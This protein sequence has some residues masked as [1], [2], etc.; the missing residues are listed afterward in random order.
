MQ[1]EPEPTGIPIVLNGF[2]DVPIL[3][4]N[5]F[6]IQYET[7][8][9]ILTAGQLTPPV[10]L[11]TEE[12]QREQ[13]KRI[14]HVSVKVVARISMNRTRLEQLNNLLTDHLRRF[15]PPPEGSP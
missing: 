5:N 15:S 2:E 4:A 14:T 6:I 10:L 12:E 9:F 7:G 1:N 11:G 8:D 3:Y 13:A